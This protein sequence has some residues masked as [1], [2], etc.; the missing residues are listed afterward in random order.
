MSQAIICEQLLARGLDHHVEALLKRHLDGKF[1]Q[2]VYGTS[3]NVITVTP[4]Y[5][6]FAVVVEGSGKSLRAWSIEEEALTWRMYVDGHS[7]ASIGM[8]IGRSI[9]AVQAKLREMRITH[10]FPERDASNARARELLA[11]GKSWKTVARMLGVSESGLRYRIDDK[12][13]KN[14]R[15]SRV[16]SKIRNGST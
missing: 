3:P 14:V 4:D 1:V 9:K 8:E 16:R 15:S 7:A 11:S 2:L 12:H 5:D 6:P 13:R 10:T